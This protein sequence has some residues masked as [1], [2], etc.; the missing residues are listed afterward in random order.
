MFVL[1]KQAICAI[2]NSGSKDSLR[3]KFKEIHILA[4]TSHYIFVNVIYIKK[5]INDFS[6]IGDIHNINTRN[7]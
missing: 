3:P 7:Q 1:H 2:Y 5:N 6:K 4:V